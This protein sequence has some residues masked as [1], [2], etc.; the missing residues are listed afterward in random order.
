MTAGSAKGKFY[1]GIY[2][3]LDERDIVHT[4]VLSTCI[5]CGEPKNIYIL[6][7]VLQEQVC[8]GCHHGWPRWSIESN[9]TFI[10]DKRRR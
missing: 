2:A 1:T 4:K 7:P 8:L 10:T 5:M 3:G 9:R 6:V